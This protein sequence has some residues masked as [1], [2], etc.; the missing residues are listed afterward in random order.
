MQVCHGCVSRATRGGTSPEVG[1]MRGWSRPHPRSHGRDARGTQSAA[2][3]RIR[4]TR[5]PCRP[6]CLHRAAGQACRAGN[7]CR[8]MLTLLREASM[9]PARGGLPRSHNCGL[10][11]VDHSHPSR[12]GDEIDCPER[13]SQPSPGSRPEG[14]HPGG[15]SHNT[16]TLKGSDR[17]SRGRSLTGKTVLW[18]PF[19]VR[20][21]LATGHSGWRGCAADPGLCCPTP[22]GSG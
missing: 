8:T 7:E 10:P 13:A 11:L 16:S 9:A 6:P 17:E 2:G 1:T 20:D 19:R 18:H 5:W 15:A 14:A 4:P 22:S 21:R 12:D 3:G